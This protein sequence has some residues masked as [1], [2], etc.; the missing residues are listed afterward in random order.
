VQGDREVD[1]HLPQQGPDL[2]HEAHRRHRHATRRR[3]IFFEYTLIAGLN[4]SLEDARR[5]AP[6]L[7]GIPCKLN[8]IPMNAHPD[9]PWRHPSD[10]VVD[11]F[12][13]EVSSVGLFATV[14]RSRG[15]DIQA[16][17]GQLALRPE[18]RRSS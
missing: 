5:L 18:T 15:P 3:P 16:A 1:R 11:A 9:S 12:F 6:L 14:R 2:R 7:R 13:R 4:D 10:A 8:L 17:C